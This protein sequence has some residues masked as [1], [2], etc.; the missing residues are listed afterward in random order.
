MTEDLKTQF[1]EIKERERNGGL[2]LVGVLFA[3]V[4]GIGGQAIYDLL[5]KP[6]FFAQTGVVIGTFVFL[7][8]IIREMRYSKKRMD[9][10][11]E[12]LK[13]LE[14]GGEN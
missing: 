3:F 9:E 1:K 10:I 2:F 6:S 12:K 7:Y 14:K 13:K 11:E 8:L 5:V 4:A